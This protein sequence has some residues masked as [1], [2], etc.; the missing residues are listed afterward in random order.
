MSGAR[1]HPQACV[2]SGAELDEGVEIGPFCHVQA[3]A[4]IGARTRLVSNV[5]VGPHTRIGADNVVYAGA[6]LGG[7]PQDKSWKGEPTTLTVG[8]GNVIRECVTMNRGTVKG[9]GATVVGNRNLFMAC[10]H[11]GHDCAIGS[12][13][14]MANAVL[15]AG[16]VHIDDRAVLAGAVACHHFVRIGRMA[17]I[18]GMS[19]IV[20]DVP[21]YTKVSGEHMRVRAL[22]LVGL[23]R[24]GIPVG[25]I[26]ELK[27]VYAALFRRNSPL[28]SV[29]ATLEA[30]A[31]TH[32]S[33]LVKFV[34]EWSSAP[35]GRFLEQFRTDRPPVAQA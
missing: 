34:R 9:G 24:G 35:S 7:P 21:P 17:Y 3:S 15:I 10:S 13:I 30:P 23:Q 8:D 4:R 29:L 22:N 14:V 18:G 20:H 25:E 11:I 1:V 12:E 28:A 6:A 2:E 5:H 16:H 33:H 31:G 27:R 19:R 26:E 32:A